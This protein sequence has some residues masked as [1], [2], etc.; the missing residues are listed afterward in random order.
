MGKRNNTSNARTRSSEDNTSA[1]IVNAQIRYPSEESDNILKS[2]EAG[3][4]LQDMET[5][6]VTL[7]PFSD[8]NI[9]L[10][11]KKTYGN[12]TVSNIAASLDDLIEGHK[13]AYCCYTKV[14]NEVILSNETYKLKK[15]KNYQLRFEMHLNGEQTERTVDRWKE[16]NYVETYTSIIDYDSYR[17]YIDFVNG[18]YYLS[19]YLY[20]GGRDISW[21]E[22]IN[23]WNLEEQGELSSNRTFSSNLNDDNISATIIYN[24]QWTDKMGSDNIKGE[25]YSK[26]EIQIYNLMGEDP[27]ATCNYSCRDYTWRHLPG[28]GELRPREDEIKISYSG[29]SISCYKSNY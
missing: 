2:I 21:E 13:Y 28:S 9:V 8:K 16:R 29:Y 3:I 10:N 22:S 18:K 1:I 23:K 17:I 11:E 5:K 26:L 27:H 25:E 24:R 6:G 15:E 4:C 7:I 19:A 20:L 12:V 14:N